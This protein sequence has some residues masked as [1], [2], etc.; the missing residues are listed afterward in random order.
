MRKKK[1]KLCNN[2]ITVR[3]MSKIQ[4][5]LEVYIR[6]KTI[7]AVKLETSLRARTHFSRIDL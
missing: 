6:R 3:M 7:S 1:N 2:R 4:I 5:I